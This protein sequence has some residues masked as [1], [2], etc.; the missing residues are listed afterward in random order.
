ML[1]GVVAAPADAHPPGPAPEPQTEPAPGQAITDPIPEE[2][3]PAEL[4]LV[5][6]ELAQVPK[7]E[8]IPPPTDSR[9]DR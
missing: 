3:I 4:G 1:A 9:L 6:T 2:P 5:L 8:P 7:S